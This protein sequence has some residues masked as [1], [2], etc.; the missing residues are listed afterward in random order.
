MS[1]RVDEARRV[2]TSLLDDLE[3]GTSTTEA[4]LLKGMRLA[5]LMRD[6]DAQL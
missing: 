3:G 2:V 1:E 5:R 6:S 4:A